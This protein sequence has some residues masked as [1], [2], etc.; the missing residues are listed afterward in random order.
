MRSL[1]VALVL[2]SGAVGDAHA[3]DI[4]VF[5]ADGEADAG[6]TDP[7][8]AALDEAFM[9]AIT[10][11]LPDVLDSDVRKANKQVIDREIVAHARKWIVKFSV[12][13]DETTEG[14]R[15]LTVTVRVD[16]DKMRARLGEL[17]IGAAAAGE[18]PGAKAGAILLRV[19]DGTTTRAT[20][21]TSGEK[22]IPGLGALAT[23]L[24]GGGFTVKR[25][26]VTGPVAR[27]AGELPLD[28]DEAEALAAEAKVE[29]A[30]VAGVTVGAPVPVRGVP[31]SAVLVSAHVRV[32]AK[33]KKL[34]GQGTATVAARGSEASVVNAAIDRAVVA[35]AGD[36]MPAKQAIAQPTAFQGDDT[37]I[38]EP[39]MVLV[40]LSPKTPYALV[41]AELKYLA[42]A[43]GIS[44]A[45]LRRMSPGGWV[46]GVT[47]TE[48]VQRIANIAKKAPVSDASA[49]VK[50]VGE[51]VEV[52]LSG[53]P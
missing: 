39:G 24:R 22:D 6:G 49:Q 3:E 15:Q 52:S 14:R 12:T 37:P 32:L 30:A 43:K 17:N 10:Q 9:R 45:A 35:A 8:V 44:R 7:R 25:A 21:G 38:G 4:A 41:A 53:A 5:D 48:S 36:V 27:P 19:S 26:P 29:V 47:T 13:K 11:A 31:S 46:I 28:D 40:R 2:I 34:V 23:L 16:R 20:Y 50:I 42:G 33:G 51:V 1:L 18:V